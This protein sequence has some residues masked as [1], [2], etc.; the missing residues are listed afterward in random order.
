MAEF[1]ALTVFAGLPVRDLAVATRWYEQI[2]GRAPDG[3]PTPQIAEYYLSGDR[4]PE[5]GTLQLRED[6]GRAGGG[7]AT[8]NVEDLAVLTATLIHLGV[9]F[10]AHNFAVDA[11]SV[12]SVTVGTFTDPDGNAV[13]VVQPNPR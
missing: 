1:E 9:A 3:R 8:I 2:F 7:L 5:R 10:E 12:S 13:T 11:E 6:A 4:V